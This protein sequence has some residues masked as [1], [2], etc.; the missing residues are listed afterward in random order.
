MIPTVLEDAHKPNPNPETAD[1]TWIQSLYMYVHVLTTT[2]IDKSALPICVINLSCYSNIDST[3]EVLRS[4]FRVCTYDHIDR[5][6]SFDRT[7]LHVLP[8]TQYCMYLAR[9]GA[10]AIGLGTRALLTCM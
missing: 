1:L 6:A 7:R 9:K 3:R 5:E 4:R 8:D 10:P 2:Y